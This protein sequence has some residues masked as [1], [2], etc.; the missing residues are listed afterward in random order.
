MSGKKKQRTGCFWPLV[1]IFSI[2]VMAVAIFV[3]LGM[4]GQPPN[5]AGITPYTIEVLIEQPQPQILGLPEKEKVGGYII[6]VEAPLPTAT[7]FGQEDYAAVDRAVREIVSAY[8]QCKKAANADP[9]GFFSAKCDEL[10]A[11][12]IVGLTEIQ[13]QQLRAATKSD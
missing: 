8:N 13:L 5:G 3:M 1:A 7:P 2:L 10:I 12:M 11:P 4:P 6:T 9:T